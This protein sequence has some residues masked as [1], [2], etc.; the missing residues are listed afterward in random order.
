MAA[1]SSS[2]AGFSKAITVALRGDEDA[3]IFK[4]TTPPPSFGGVAEKIMSLKQCSSNVG[5]QYVSCLEA[6][7]RGGGLQYIVCI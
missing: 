6:G 5:I 3:K 4:V 2:L 7:I 1:V